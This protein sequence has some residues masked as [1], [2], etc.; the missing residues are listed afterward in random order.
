MKSA[1]PVI[2]LL[3]IMLAF[4]TPFSYGAPET[5]SIDFT[6]I[7]INFDKTDAFFTVNYDIGELPRLFV[8]L[9]GSKSLEPQ[10]R[11]VLSGFD[12]DIIKMDQDKAVL[13]VKN[14]SRFDKGYYLHDSI[15]FGESIK[16]V[17]YIYTPDSPE[18]KK[19]S[20][21]YLFDWS[22]VPGSDNGKL[23]NFLRNDLEINWTKN[24]EIKK[25]NDKTIRVFSGNDSI[26]MVLVN[27]V[28]GIIKQ[29]NGKTNDLEVE[30]DRGKPYIYS[31]YLYSTP[32]IVYRS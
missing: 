32:D 21:L 27:N 2:V 20:R 31:P 5:R 26:D 23:L 8:L 3:V 13:K 11:A 1:F 16:T 17:L 9:M 18:P 24:A 10:L 22:N 14:I 29:S 25:L 28:K 19:Y 4:L 6:S 7:T 12:Y 15:R 30:M